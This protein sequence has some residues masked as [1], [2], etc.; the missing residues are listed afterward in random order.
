MG[1]AASQARFLN[2]TARRTNIEYHGQQINQQRTELANESANLYNQ[3]LS[4]QVPVP[5]N[6]QDYTKVEYSF[7][8]PGNY[9]TQATVT[10]FAKTTTPGEYTV[11]FNYT[12][13]ELGFPPCTTS[14]RSDVENVTSL[15]T[16]V[17][18]ADDG[19]TYL[20]KKTGATEW[21]WSTDN[22]TNTNSFTPVSWSATLAEPMKSAWNQLM[23]ENVTTG[24]LYRTSSSSNIF[25]KQSDIE[26]ITST[27]GEP[28]TSYT[29]TTVNNGNFEGQ[30]I[31]TNKG[32]TAELKYV[33]ANDP[34]HKDAYDELSN[35]GADDVWVANVGTEDKPVYQ[36]YRGSEIVDAQG[37]NGDGHALYYTA[38]D[39]DVFHEDS[40]TP[41]TISR[42]GNGR[43]QSFNYKGEDYA[44]TANTIT[45]DE[46]YNDAMNEYTY[47]SYLYE[48]EMNRI[49]AKTS[50]VQAQDRELELKLK[51]L[52]TEHNAVQTE[53]DAVKGVCK[54]NVEDSFKTFA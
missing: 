53:M 36:Y 42:D 6:T 46:A 50:I 39:I 51:Q 23:G 52:D 2:L 10:Q 38:S 1:M 49:N 5:P 8:I 54:K 31:T 15:G 7:N 11:V 25:F 14:Q 17:L 27:T 35:G 34:I 32:K 9:D 26:S 18:T 44:V 16:R 41:V 21:K 40:Y 20:V 45:D 29:A 24:K 13:K 19:S 12:Q 37:A 30:T 33:S 28:V 43:V 48:Q 22:W 4:L 47:Q 3:M